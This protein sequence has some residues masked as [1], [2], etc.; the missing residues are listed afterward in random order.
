[1]SDKPQKE[2]ASSADAAVDGGDRKPL[3]KQTAKT[4]QDG[5][6]LTWDLLREGE[7]RPDEAADFY[8]SSV[9]ALKK[10][11]DRDPRTEP[12]LRKAKK[13]KDDREK[14]FS[15]I[16]LGVVVGVALAFLMGSSRGCADAGY[17]SPRYYRR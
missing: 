1:M 12:V 9:E 2:Q 3:H 14:A 6:E 4:V 7:L 10:F 16:M 13:L 5:V 17:D 8:V 11:K 15:N